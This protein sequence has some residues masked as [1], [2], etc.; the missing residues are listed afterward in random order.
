MTNFAT[1]T[2]LAGVLALSTAFGAQAERFGG[3]A[4]L[5]PKPWILTR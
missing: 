3:R 5:I 2:T 1:K 4:T